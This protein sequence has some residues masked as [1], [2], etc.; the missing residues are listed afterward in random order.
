MESS[1]LQELEQI[2]GI[3]KTIAQDIGRT[4]RIRNN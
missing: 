2:P 4:G 3:G 1:S